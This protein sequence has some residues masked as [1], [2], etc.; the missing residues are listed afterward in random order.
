MFL[1]ALA[2]LFTACDDAGTGKNKDEKKITGKKKDKDE[3]AAKDEDED[4]DRDDDEGEEDDE[5]EDGEDEDESGDRDDEDDEDED[6]DN[7]E[8]RSS[9]W[10]GA[11]RKSFMNECTT[12][13][14]ATMGNTI[15]AEKYC[16][17]MMGKI[18]TKYPTKKV[19][20]NS[21]IPQMSNWAK[22]CDK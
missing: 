18:E 21:E 6:E 15:N 16:S 20:D 1:F 10:S 19:A 14:K 8:T 4:G 7:D 5:D 3:N 9:G 12:A 13:T 22:Q 11:D 2:F 17:C